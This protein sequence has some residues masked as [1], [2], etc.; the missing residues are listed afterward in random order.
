MTLVGLFS[1]LPA[2]GFGE[3]LLPGAPGVAAVTT[4]I[5][6]LERQRSLG[7][8]E[9]ARYLDSADSA[10]AARAALAIGRTKQ[11]AG[12]APL[13]A[14]LSAPDPG[15]RAMLVYALGLL[16]LPQTR[17]AL[18]ARLGDASERVRYA[19]L[20][21]V[22]R[23]ADPNAALAPVLR[24]LSSDPSPSVRG[25]AA[26]TLA[27]FSTS[28]SP[29][30]AAA[31]A[32]AAAYARER[33]PQTRW[34]IMWAIFRAYAK[35]VPLTVLQKGLS[36]PDTTVRIEAVRAYGRLKP[37]NAKAA[38]PLLATLKRM[39]YDPAWRVQEQAM[40]SLRV[41]QGGKFSEHL[42]KLPPGL[43]LPPLKVQN[44]MEIAPLPRPAFSGKPAAPATRD[45]RLDPVLAPR[46][47]AQMNGPMPGKHPRVR[48]KTTKGTIVLRLYPEWAPLTVANFL[49]MTNRGYYDGNRWFRIVPDFVVQT[50]DPNGNGEG[51]AGFMIGA[52]ENPIEQRSG[53]VSM[54]LNYNAKGA[55]R[56]SAG[57][58]FYITISPQLHLNNDFTVFGEV[59][60]GFEVIARL[61]ESDRMT[62][63]E[64][65][66]DD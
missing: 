53:I 25:K 57:T 37:A 2:L 23:L 4:R 13:L 49:N 24:L 15:E 41:L 36:D 12:V 20:D 64:Q 28:G 50:G 10:I 27:A 61:I 39:I 54:G 42:S 34:H 47:A 3:T 19:A 32:L 55:I 18:T 21:A 46:S 6:E 9:L 45:A 52:E 16:A 56:D 44:F 66:A 48:I 59:E 58:Q 5:L 7:D 38:A 40:E 35:L 30:R 62:R 65:I 60:S 31:G 43:H 22:G 11:P 1:G 29:A 63:V 51:D 14:H 26:G 17:A 33:E 8:G